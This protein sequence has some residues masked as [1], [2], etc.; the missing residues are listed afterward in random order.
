LAKIKTAFAVA[1]LCGLTGG[2]SESTDLSS[3]A[4]CEEIMM[5]FHSSCRF[6]FVA[7]LFAFG[8]IVPASAQSRVQVGVLE[9]EGPGS[10]SFVVGSINQFDCILRSDFGPPQGYLAT[11]RR[12]GVDVGFSRATSLR[13]VVFA[14]TQQVGYGALAGGY[15]GPS[16]GAAVGVGLNANVLVGGSYNS[17][18]LQPLSFSGQLGLN[19]AAGIADLELVP[20]GRYLGRHHHHRHHY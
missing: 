5:S 18:A 2:R 1:L 13:W 12:Y 19:V 9:C 4:I 10:V 3:A 7:L 6:V 14:P 8:A 17:F 11:I 20:A 16:A 15:V